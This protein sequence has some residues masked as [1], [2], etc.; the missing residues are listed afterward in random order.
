MRLRFEEDEPLATSR[1]LSR[2]LDR[3]RARA[4]ATRTRPE[5]APGAPVVLQPGQLYDPDQDRV[6]VV[7]RPLSENELRRAQRSNPNPVAPQRPKQRLF[8]S[9]GGTL[10]VP[11]SML[12]KSKKGEASLPIGTRVQAKLTVGASSQSRRPVLAAVVAPVRNAGR[13]VFP[14]GT[15]LVGRGSTDGRRRFFIDF[16]EASVRGEKMRFDGYAVSEGDMPGLVAMRRAASVE[17]RSRDGAMDGAMNGAE[18]VVD[19]IVGQSLP[20]RVAQRIARGSMRGAQEGLQ[21]DRSVVFEVA[22]GTAFEVLVV[23]GRG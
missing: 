5:R 14:V 4:E 17:E 7:T 10:D 3:A 18:A 12:N 16:Y 20:G 8:F 22:A 2:A 21:V 11:E 19:E 9:P 13:T 15:V 1:D 23:G 6:E